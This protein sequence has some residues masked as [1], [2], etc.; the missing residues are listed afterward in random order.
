MLSASL[1]S[2]QVMFIN[3]DYFQTI[4]GMI[5]AGENYLLFASLN[6]LQLLNANIRATIDVTIYRCL[7]STRSFFSV[8]IY[9]YARMLNFLLKTPA[10]VGS[11]HQ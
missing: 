11:K 5:S 10:D 8:E 2:F 4:S 9:T 6:G 3:D 1:H 7:T